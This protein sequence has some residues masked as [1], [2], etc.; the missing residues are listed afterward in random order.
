VVV[1]HLE[2]TGVKC[3]KL[4]VL[5]VSIL[6]VPLAVAQVQ[7]PKERTAT[8]SDREV[9][10]RPEPKFTELTREEGARLDQ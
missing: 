2:I 9:R 5:A 6:A 7:S 1:G 4:V 8:V 3:A 10:G